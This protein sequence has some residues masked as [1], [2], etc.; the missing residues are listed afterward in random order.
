MIMEPKKVKTT[1]SD[2]ELL[3]YFQ[4]KI[5]EVDKKLD[6]LKLYVDEEKFNRILDIV[7]LHTELIELSLSELEVKYEISDI[8]DKIITLHYIKMN[9]ER[10]VKGLKNRI[11]K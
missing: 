5:T 4:Y 9:F 3:S 11:E 8:T 7:S 1:V 6:M 10:I 2:D